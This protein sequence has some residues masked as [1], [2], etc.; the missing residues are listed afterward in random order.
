[1]NGKQ[2]CK[3]TGNSIETAQKKVSN[4]KKKILPCPLL[5]PTSTTTPWEE[6]DI[7][8]VV[9]E[10][11]G[12]GQGRNWYLGGGG[13]RWWEEGAGKNFFL[14][15]DTFFYIQFKNT[16]NLIFPGFKVPYERF[17][18]K[19]FKTGLTF[20]HMWFFNFQNL[21]RSCNNIGGTPCIKWQKCARS[22]LNG[23]HIR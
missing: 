1:M 4:S 10:G 15:F 14:E 8:G 20:W 9:V 23:F 6:I 11:G 21:L 19:N 18:F 17:L 5:P 7:E 22:Y 16:F 2:H 3:Q 12:R 13:G